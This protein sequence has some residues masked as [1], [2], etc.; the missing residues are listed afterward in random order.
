MSARL[1][2]SDREGGSFLPDSTRGPGR[3]LD[4]YGRL[5]GPLLAGYLLFDRAFAYLHPP[6]TPF[7]IGEIVLGAGVLGVLGATGY[8][9]IP[10]RDEPLLALLTV[11]VLWGFVRAV[12]GMAEYGMDAI[13]DSALWYYCLFAFLGV[14][15]LARSPDLPD[16]LVVQLRRLAP[17]LLLWLPAALLLGPAAE[18]APYV[19]FSTVS[20]LSHKPGNAAIAALLVLG[21]LWLIRDDRSSTRRM[22]WSVLALTVILLSATQNRGGL[23]GVAAGAT[24]GLLFLKDRLRL[25]I[26]AVLLISVTVGFVSFLRIDIP[27]AGIQGRTFSVSQLVDN[28][29]SLGGGD[30]EGN[31]DG[32][33]EGREQLWSKIIAKQVGEGH[34][35]DGSGFGQNLASEVGV[36][37]AGKESLRSPH[38][39]HLHILARMGVVGF[40]LWVVLWAAWYWRL[41]SGARRL[42]RQALHARRQFAVLCLVVVT[43][44]LISSIFDPQLEGPQIAVL[45]WTAFGLGVGVTTKRAWLDGGAP[46]SRSPDGTQP[47]QGRR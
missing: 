45:L 44:I 3:L 20:V 36:Y 14:A 40:S 26:Q 25:G 12:P 15:A 46:V 19:P 27:L 16:R 9:R 43:A 39:S 33:V 6:G 41:V 2:T 7:Y 31:L 13:R 1:P 18:K 23:L 10:M 21:F 28:I 34:L 17:W 8:L 5:L 38:N 47:A 32:T 4:L 42:G 11:F 35:I 22:A 24:I 30:A 37:D 29:G